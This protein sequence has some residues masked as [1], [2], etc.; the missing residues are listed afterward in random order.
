MVAG[1]GTVGT[2]ASA[3][4]LGAPLSSQ[5]SLCDLSTWPCL[6]FLAALC[7]GAIGRLTWWLRAP[8]QFFQQQSRR[9]IAFDDLASDFT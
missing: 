9:R 8:G 4:L 6:G 1:A 3:A 2:E 5:G 7:L